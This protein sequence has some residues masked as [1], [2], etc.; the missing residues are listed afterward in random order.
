MGKTIILAKRPDLVLKLEKY[1]LVPEGKK[2][3][4]FEGCAKKWAKERTPPY[5]NPEYQAMAARL[6]TGWE[7]LTHEEMKELLKKL[8]QVIEQK[9]K[10]KLD[11]P[12]RGSEKMLKSLA[13]IAF[14]GIST[15]AT[16]LIE[17]GI[18]ILPDKDEKEKK[19]AK[20]FSFELV[21]HLIIG[22]GFLQRIFRNIAETTNTDRKNQEHIAQ[23][24]TMTAIFMAILAASD[25]NEDRLKRLV[26]SFRKTFDK[27]IADIETF[28][29]DK[30]ANAGL[31]G[32]KAE[33]AALYL[34]QARMALEKEDFEGFY[35]AFTGALAIA[36]VAPGH[37]IDDMKRISVYAKNL[38]KTIHASLNDASNQVTA[39]SQSM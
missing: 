14:L 30:L 13:Q 34:Q 11:I 37:F 20:E 21:L 32:D 17:N 22:T 16:L 35:E 12:N 5:D 24:L 4:I 9:K 18:G 1:G 6:P 26:I 31:T 28:V 15:A 2:G 38:Q 7:E 39:M 36:N 8:Q 27:G 3:G 19:L 23:V 10:E 29:S 25:G 33:R